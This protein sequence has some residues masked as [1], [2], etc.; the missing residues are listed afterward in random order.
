MFGTWSPPP[1]SAAVACAAV[2]ETLSTQRM[3]NPGSL[4][5]ATGGLDRKVRIW[6]AKTYEQLA[7]LSGHEG[8]INTLEWQPLAPTAGDS[9]GDWRLFSSSGDSTAR[10]WEPRP[11][12]ARVEAREA[13]KAALERVEPMVSRLFAEL[14]DAG[15][16]IERIKSDPSLSALHR[17]T[18]LQMVL[19]R[20][21]DQGAAG[22]V[23]SQPR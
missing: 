10:I 8:H 19:A 1:P 6:D 20:G 12:R 18:A 16:V 22:P 9:A 15:Q 3:K 23:M 4:D 11:I 13:R 5:G 7:A 17:K 21:L 2:V 14:K